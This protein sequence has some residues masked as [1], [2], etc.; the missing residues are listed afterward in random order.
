MTHLTAALLCAAAL[1]FGAAATLWVATDG[2]SAED[3]PMMLTVF[4][5]VTEDAICRM[6]IYPLGDEE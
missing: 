1:A 4:D 6:P 2:A 5:G 3:R